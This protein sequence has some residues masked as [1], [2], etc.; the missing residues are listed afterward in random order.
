MIPWLWRLASHSRSRLAEAEAE[1]SRS[2][3]A[4]E[5]AEQHLSNPLAHRNQRNHYSDII[6]DAL[7][8]GYERQHD[9]FHYE[10]DRN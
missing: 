7:Q 10:E 5:E 9:S 1:V 6:R 2:R 4:L 3:A 8:L